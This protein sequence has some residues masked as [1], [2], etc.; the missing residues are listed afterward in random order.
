MNIQPNESQAF[1]CYEYVYCKRYVYAYSY[2]KNENYLK[3]AENIA[4]YLMTW[5]FYF[6]VP[7]DKLTD[8]GQLNIKTVGGTAVSVA[9]HIDC[10]GLF[11]VP[12]MLELYELTNNRAYLLHAQDL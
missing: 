4:H 12:G 5:A 8:C 3:M 1:C 2:T 10:W 6:N 11:Y 9:H 7:F